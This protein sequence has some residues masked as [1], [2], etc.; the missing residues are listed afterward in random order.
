ALLLGAG[1][2]LANGPLLLA[3]GPLI[4][5]RR[6]LHLR[7][8]GL[9]LALHPLLFGADL[10]LAPFAFTS[11]LLF[12][13]RLTFRAAPLGL[14][15]A[16]GKRLRATCLT[17]GLALLAALADLF[18]E[19]RQRPRRIAR[20]AA[21]GDGA[22]GVAAV[23]GGAGGLFT[24]QFLLAGQALGS[25]CLGPFLARDQPFATLALLA[26]AAQL[27]F[28]GALAV[29]APAILARRRLDPGRARLDHHR[30]PGAPL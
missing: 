25:A 6:A 12:G 19:R 18:S 21:L 13:A 16:L 5:A 2:N 29:G 22:R 23:G 9:R 10:A 28:A 14:R 27:A 30:P 24:D 7:A 4:G 11:G 1:S 17:L 20:R 8:V 3:A 15:T 26:E